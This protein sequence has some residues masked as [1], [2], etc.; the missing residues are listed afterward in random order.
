MKSRT[1][2]WVAGLL[3]I[4]Y[5]PLSSGIFSVPTGSSI[6]HAA[7]KNE[8][9]GKSEKGEKVKLPGNLNAAHASATARE[10]ANPNSQV[11]KIA[12]YEALARYEECKKD[13]AAVGCDS[14]L[15]GFVDLDLT[16]IGDVPSSGSVL[17][18]ASNKPIVDGEG[19]VL[20]EVR[21][22]I[23]SLLGITAVT[24]DLAPVVEVVIE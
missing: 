7:G 15:D 12:R 1:F 21:D 20:A 22:A 18:E 8:S 11:G 16:S 5:L 9:S 19:N 13:S 3:V 24:S 17:I 2:L 14:Y 6:A 10:H 23:Y 4:T